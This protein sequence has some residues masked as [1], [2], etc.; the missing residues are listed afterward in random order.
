MM[1]RRMR[2]AHPEDV[3]M[4]GSSILAAF[5]LSGL[6]ASAGDAK[7][8]PWVED[9]LALARQIESEGLYAR[10]KDRADF[11]ER[12]EAASGP[13]KLRL[14][15]VLVLQA[16]AA[17]DTEA[18][19]RD[20]PRFRAEINAQQSDRYRTSA[21]LIEVFLL[22]A[23]QNDGPRATAKVEEILQ[24]VPLDAHQQV[25]AYQFL[26][27]AYCDALKTEKALASVRRGYEVL[28][29]HP[30]EPGDRVRMAEA[31]GYVLDTAGDYPGMVSALRET[32]EQG[33]GLDVPFDGASFVH[34][35]S[36][37]LMNVGKLQAARQASEIFGR[38]ADKSGIQLEM[39]FAR[40]LC[41]H[42]AL[43]LK[44]FNTARDCFLGARDLV[45]V[46]GDRTRSLQLSLAETYL[47]LSN[48]EM[49]EEILR[50]VQADPNLEKNRMDQLAAERLSLDLLQ[51]RGRHNEAYEG[52]VEHF[53]GKLKLR[54]SELE[55]I[56]SELRS[57]T[58]A[59]AAELE[60]RADLLRS[61]TTLQEKVIARQHLIA[62]LGGIVILGA[63]F[64]I[65]RLH[66][67]SRSLR[68]ARN[69]ALA[70]SA[71]KSEFLANMSHEIRTPMYGVLGM[72]ELLQDTPLN[73]RQWTF[74][75]TIHKSGSALLTIIND[76]LDFSKIEAGK[77]QL[78]PAPFELKSAVEDVAAL[79]ANAAREKGVELSIRVQPDLPRT[80]EADGGRIRQV[81]TNLVGNAVKFT[82]E[83][84]VLIEVTGQ[85]RGDRVALRVGIEDT[86][87][88]ISK[89][90]VPVVFEQFT[91]A[92]GS[93]T[94]KYG[95]TGLGLSITK[96]LVEAMGGT[97]G[98]KSELG[99]GSTF[100][101]T[102]EVPAVRAIDIEVVSLEAR[103]VLVVDDLAVNREILFEQ[104]MGWGLDVTAAS[105]GQEA[106]VRL[107]QAV[108]DGERF[109][110]VVTD[111]QMPQM[112]GAAL[113]REIAS[114]PRLSATKIIVASSADRRAT[115]DAFSSL[116]TAALL[117][118]PLRSAVLY[119]E[120]ERALTSTVGRV[121]V[122]SAAVVPES[123]SEAI[124][125]PDHREHFKVLVAED[126]VVNRRIL[127]NMIDRR[128]YSTDFAEDGR[129]AYEAARRERY[130]V[131]LMDISM[132]E[133]DGIE[134]TKAIRAQEDSCLSATTP[135]IALTAHAME[136]DRQRFLAAG[137]NDYLTKPVR[138][139]DLRATMAKWLSDADT[140]R[141]A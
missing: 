112:D 43:D 21:L 32:V 68:E 62:L 37:V 64:F 55:K 38:I 116:T 84:Y 9:G 51:A 17:A 61:Q 101:V 120:I 134:A 70:A 60:E 130:D 96:S 86:G 81:L 36:I 69:Q 137:M 125:V 10:D 45:H 52:L 118:K 15:E 14:L 123:T 54:D 110:L 115:T 29:T 63:V 97:I 117:S 23:T 27:H 22:K 92:E 40:M 46:V 77:M 30:V 71:V 88:G 67:T 12:A 66:R 76:I 83:G 5:V 49:A 20:L 89:E 19:Q 74:V 44:D 53:E 133:M 26:A 95:G 128:R 48:I 24:T 90:K 18:I 25:L 139:A 82:N 113:V 6:V 119:A 73:D 80:V 4:G 41:G 131:I 42:V 106:L 3:T 126:N 8:A 114:D 99:Q 129:Q 58:A 141:T 107:R 87:I 59:R 140:A 136:G 109:E 103:R 28:S 47:R 13:E 16:V 105:S 94:R 91:Q 75:D 124:T 79:I 50:S 35:L 33:K 102:L 135:I 7:S 108:D 34:N 98:V 138:K 78:D 85:V 121:R 93:T 111:Y 127:E 72:A 2:R 56:A 11:R 122:D 39:F 132:P 104:L 65:V 57:L 31:R 1:A 100:W